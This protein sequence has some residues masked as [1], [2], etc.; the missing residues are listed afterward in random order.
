MRT[1]GLEMLLEQMESSIQKM[2]DIVDKVQNGEL[3]AKDICEIEVELIVD[4]FNIRRAVNTISTFLADF[5]D[6]IK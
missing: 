4:I 6:N 5:V 1:G 3:S 2:K